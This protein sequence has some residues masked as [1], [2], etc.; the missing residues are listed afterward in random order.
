MATGAAIGSDV[1]TAI[2]ALSDVDK[3]DPTKCWQTICT[4]FV[5]Y[6]LSGTVPPAID[7][8]S[9]ESTA[10]AS[11]PVTP[12][13]YISAGG[14]PTFSYTATTTRL[15]RIECEIT[16]IPTTAADTGRFC[17]LIDGTFQTPA[18]AFQQGSYTWVASQLNTI[19]RVRFGISVT[20]TAGTHTI[21]VGWGTL[22]SGFLSTSTSCWVNYMVWG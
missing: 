5:T 14:Y 4:V 13:P 2:N 7:I 1:V 8:K 20:L 22:A 9:Q 17:L 19:I 10:T 18:N 16:F 3:A 6:G 21:G 15:F 11:G 12:A